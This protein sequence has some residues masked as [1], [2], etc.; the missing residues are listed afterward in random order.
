MH[1]IYNYLN[2]FNNTNNGYV[3]INVE[4][5]NC[6]LPIVIYIPTFVLKLFSIFM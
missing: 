2:K 6:L 3:R 4:F 1:T 5:K